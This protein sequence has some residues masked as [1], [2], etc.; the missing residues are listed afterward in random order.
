MA[1]ID[2]GT[3]PAHAKHLRRGAT[4]ALFGVACNGAVHAGPR[5]DAAFAYEQFSAIEAAALACQPPSRE[6]RAGFG[7]NLAS[8]RA[9]AVRTLQADGLSRAQ[10]E[11]E[12]DRRSAAQRSRV[13]AMIDAS[14]CDSDQMI[15]L[16]RRYVEIG[17]WDP[18]KG[19]FPLPPP[20]PVLSTATQEALL[21]AAGY[22]KSD[23]AWRNEC[24]RAIDPAFTPVRL[25]GKTQRQVVVTSVDAVCY[26]R[27][28]RRNTVLQQQGTAWTP[29]AELTGMLGVGSARTRGYRDL[30]LGEPGYC[31]SGL[32]RW[33]GRSYDYACNEADDIDAQQRRTC[34][35]APSAITW[36]P[37]RTGIRR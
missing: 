11:A 17:G 21:A 32:Y 1:R 7:Q 28:E 13:T 10:A 37:S 16:L 30:V 27:S 34:T 15:P 5:A 3:M 35:A 24:G 19:P 8:A 2:E 12:A 25:G 6:D 4:V 33:N 26:G 14:G 18:H 22:T 31:G 29:L 23:G 36:C 20:P 9:G